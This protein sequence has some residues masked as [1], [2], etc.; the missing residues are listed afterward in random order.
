MPDVTFLMK[1]DPGIGK[2]RIQ[3]ADQDRLDAEKETFHREVYQGY[4]DLEHKYPE[5]ILGIDASRS[6]EEIKDDIC[7]KLEE[8]LEGVSL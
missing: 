2:G 8:V 3:V 6:I 4:L 1:V 7:R 5:R